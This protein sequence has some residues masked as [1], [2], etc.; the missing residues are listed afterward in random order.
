MNTIDQLQAT[1]A[2][3]GIEVD[4]R[5]FGSEI[6]LH[7]D[8]FVPGESFTKFLD[9]YHHAFIILNIK[10]EGIEKDVIKF[11]EERG[12]QEYFLLDVT[13]P[14]IIKLIDQGVTKIAVRYSEVESIETCWNFRGLVDWVFVDN[15]THLPTDDECFARL[16]KHFHLCIVSP[17]LLNR[18][19]IEQTKILIKSN[20]VDA[21]LTD[22]INKWLGNAG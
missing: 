21:V 8:P 16:R 11:V 22:D 2:E 14:F 12:I 10:C 20:P 9:A 4:I 13:T 15:I 19:E 1:P 6:V 17:E 3:Y 7:H 18:P 5:A